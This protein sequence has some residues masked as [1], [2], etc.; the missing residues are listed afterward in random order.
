MKITQ[1]KSFQKFH[2][3][4]DHESL[5][6][7]TVQRVDN[8]F[9]TIEYWI[10]D[11]ELAQNGDENVFKKCICIALGCRNSIVATCF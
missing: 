2:L 3:N 5:Q 7:I 11:M 4:S 1:H 10:F 9:T 6:V 8:L